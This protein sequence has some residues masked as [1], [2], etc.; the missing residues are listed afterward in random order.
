MLTFAA[1]SQLINENLLV[2][3]PPS[4]KIDFKDRKPD[5]LINEMVPEDQTVDDWSEMV[6]VQIFYGL[7]TTSEEFENR[8]ADGWLKARARRPVRP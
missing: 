5:R 4:Y 6:T 8:V 3:I 7:K 1:S 2:T